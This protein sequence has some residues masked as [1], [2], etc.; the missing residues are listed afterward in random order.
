MGYVYTQCTLSLQILQQTFFHISIHR[1]MLPKCSFDLPGHCWLLQHVLVQWYSHEKIIK[2]SVP[3]NSSHRYSIPH[4]CT[5]I[6]ADTN[7][8]AS[9][10]ETLVVKASYFH[11]YQEF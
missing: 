2:L 6:S 3:Q 10:G 1:K 11:I 4:H 8:D 5:G 9:I 7:T